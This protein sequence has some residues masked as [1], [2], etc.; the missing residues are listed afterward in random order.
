MMTG[1][2]E[3]CA[4]YSI[5]VILGPENGASHRRSVR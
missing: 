2:P 3:E 4:G 5:R 1:S